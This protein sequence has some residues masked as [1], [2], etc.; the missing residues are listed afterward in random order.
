M[1]YCFVI[2]M[3]CSSLWT[4][5][6]GSL[7]RPGESFDVGTKQATFCLGAFFLL[8]RGLIRTGRLILAFL[9]SI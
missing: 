7:P 9:G 3:Q 6:I 8:I 5:K 1:A 4:E 2:T